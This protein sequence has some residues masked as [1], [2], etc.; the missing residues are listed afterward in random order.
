MPLVKFA[1][2]F[3]KNASPRSLWAEPKLQPVV[4]Q[5]LLPYLELLA[6]ELVSPGFV[7]NKRAPHS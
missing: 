4:A 3:S 6:K 2:L 7:A 1:F 5:G